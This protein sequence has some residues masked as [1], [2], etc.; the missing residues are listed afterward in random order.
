M[1]VFLLVS[2]EHKRFSSGSVLEFGGFL[3]QSMTGRIA[4][5]R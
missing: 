3:V 4:Y 1:S 5:S 2:L